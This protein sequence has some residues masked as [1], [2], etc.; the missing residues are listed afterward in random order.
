[1]DKNVILNIVKDKTLTYDQKVISLARAAEDSLSVLKIDRGIQHYKDLGIICDMFE[2]A[3]PY[4]PRY[5]VVDFEKFMKQGS[6][7]LRLPP[8]K[9]IWEATN[10]LLILYRHIPSITSFPVYIGNI[11]TLLEPF[12]KDEKEAKKA[13]K[14]FLI[15]IDRTLT[16][17]F[18]HANIGPKKTKIGKIILKL[19]SELQNAVPNL[20]IKYNQETPDDFAIDAIKTALKVAKPSFANDDMFKGDWGKKY[21]IVSC[22]NGLSIGGGSYTLSRINFGKLLS[23]VKD[24]TH[25]LEKLIPDVVEKMVFYMDE[26]IK[27]LME[28]S[29]FFQTSFLVSEGL[30]KQNRFTAMFGIVGLANCV[31]SLLKA[32]KQ[33]DRFGHSKKADDIGIEIVEKLQSEL[34]NYKNKYLNATGGHYVLH[35]QVGLDSDMGISP[36]CRIPIG[37]EPELSEHL[38]KSARF[39]KYFPSGIGDIF[40]FDST[41]EKNPEYILDIIKGAFKDKMRYFSLYS[42][43]CDVVRITGY[44]VK[45]SDIQKLEKGEQVLHDS[46]VLGYG[47]V[48]NQ[49][50]LDRQVRAN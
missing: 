8:P 10:S 22:Y 14:L 11:D 2:G 36:G 7:F 24:K 39:H 9:D 49:K 12:V 6:E 28:K 38:P 40:N 20:T 35:A 50:V 31:N 18:C 43:N 29:N 5:I 42:T 33:S 30:I 16:D 25:L 45:R 3:A 15:S 48:K 1:M 26:R 17:S 37:D 47:A 32:T 13:V 21:G 34:K 19:E 44:L 4:R 27:F 46:V 41:V 23:I